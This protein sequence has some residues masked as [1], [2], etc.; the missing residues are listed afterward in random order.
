MRCR[1]KADL[2]SEV[3]KLWRDRQGPAYPFRFK[4]WSDFEA[5]DVEHRHRRRHARGVPIGQAYDLIF[6]VTRAIQLPVRAPSRF[7]SLAC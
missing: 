5:T 4:D 1:G 6:V 7:R 3:I 2:L